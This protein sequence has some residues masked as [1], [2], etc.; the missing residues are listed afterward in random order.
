MLSGLAGRFAAG[1]AF[2]APLSMAHEPRL[3]P[4]RPSLTNIMQRLESVRV[5]D[6]IKCCGPVAFHAIP[7]KM[8]FGE[9]QFVN[10]IWHKHLTVDVHNVVT[11]RVL[12]DERD[13]GK[14]PPAK[15]GLGP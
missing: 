12:H 5:A 13:G 1:H 7:P 9:C 4:A 11:L 10:S 3:L 2:S 8:N 15:A 14:I 6:R